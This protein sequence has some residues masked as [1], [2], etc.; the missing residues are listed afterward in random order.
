[1][2]QGESLKNILF[3]YSVSTE[4]IDKILNLLKKE[5]NLKKLNTNSEIE[6]TIDQ[7]LDQIIEFKFPIS[8]SKYLVFRKLNKNEEF[9]KII[10]QTNL[11]KK[12]I[13]E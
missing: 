5:T 9:E 6:F 3:K 4:E 11:T 7:S 2:S 10:T 1:M 8:K 13:Y 12:I